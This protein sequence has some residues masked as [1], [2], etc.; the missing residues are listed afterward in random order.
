MFD[1]HFKRK[2]NVMNLQTVL[3]AENSIKRNLKTSHKFELIYSCNYNSKYLKE[4]EY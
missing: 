4:I 1:S 2:T 3:K